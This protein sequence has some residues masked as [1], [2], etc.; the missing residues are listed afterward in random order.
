MLMKNIFYGLAILS[1]IACKTEP[2]KTKVANITSPQDYQKYLDQNESGIVD[3]LKSEIAQLKIEVGED[4]TRIGLNA[5]IAG[6][7]DNLF[8]LTGEVD[9]LNESV[10][11]RESVSKNTYVK[12][13]SSYRSIAQAY[14]KQHRFKRADSLM[15]SFTTDYSSQES[16][17]VQFDVAM[18]LGEYTKAENL[19]DSLHNTSDYN[20][21]TRAAKWNDHIG[22]LETTVTLMERAMK[23]ADQSGNVGRRLWSY[24]NIADYYGHNGQLEKSYENYLKTLELDPYN[25]YALKGIAWIAYSN[26]RDPEEARMI[27]EAIQKRHPLPDYNLELAELAAFENDMERSM[28]LKNK[29]MKS[30]DDP[31][32]GG[33]YNAYMISELIDAGKTQEAVDLAYKEVSN[34]ATPEIYGLLG[35]ALLKNGNPKQALTNH[36]EHVIGK[37]FEPVAQFHTALILKANGMIEE[38]NQFK[39]ELLET[40]YEMGPV[41]FKEIQSI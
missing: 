26:D 3:S 33:M 39:N 9:Y 8:D 37:T 24:S 32:Y 2:E 25:T 41:T 28:E 27:L 35:Y 36:E 29:F 20:Y 14:I 12:P 17:M 30:V 34:R 18:E 11:L 5:R 1:L 13:E 4:S 40:E 6:K 23:L 38:A 7:L 19:L 16:K 21:L 10:R 15:S 31:A 22:Q